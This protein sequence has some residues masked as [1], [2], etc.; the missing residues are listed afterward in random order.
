MRFR[1]NDHSESKIGP[2]WGVE[3]EDLNATALNWRP[4]KS[5]AAHVNTEVDVVLAVL[6]G[7]GSLR[8]DGQEF[9]LAAGDVYIIP[10]GTEREV[11]A[12]SNGLRYINIHKRRRGLTP[13]AKRAEL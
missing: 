2:I 8:I 11:A 9:D 3:T 5:V 13:G 10:K 12:G 1:S 6:A 4:G 7:G